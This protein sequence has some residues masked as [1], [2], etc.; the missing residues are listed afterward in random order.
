MRKF[1]YFILII[2]LSAC[3]E[4]QDHP[5]NAADSTLSI[6]NRCLT[7]L[8]LK[9]F[10]ASVLAQEIGWP[11]PVWDLDNLSLA[12][13]YFHPDMA[14]AQAIA[15]TADAANITAAQR[16]NPTLNAT[17][18][19]LTHLATAVAPWYAVSSLN[20][21]IET[22]G[23]RGF[24]MDKAQQLSAA[25]RLRIADAAWA[26][27]GRL[28]LAW[29]EAFAAQE[30]ERLA[31]QQLGL[32]Q[33]MATRLEQQLAAGEIS[34]Q[35]LLRLQLLLSQAQLNEN[36]AQKR[37]AESRVQLATALG[38]PVDALKEVALD[39]NRL[40]QAPALDSIPVSKLREIALRQ[41]PD[42]L[43][44]LADYAAAQ[45]ALQLE[46]AN[47]YPNIQANPG[48]AWEL[49]ENLWSLGAS[50]QLP[51]F[52]QNQG[53]IAEAEAKR[54]ELAVRFTALQSK[55]IGDIDRAHAGV[56]AVLAKQQHTEQQKSLQQ[57]N[58]WFAQAQFNAGEIDHL[59]LLTAEMEAVIAE[60]TRLDVS[61]ETQQTLNTLEDS[62]RTPINSAFNMSLIDNSA[63]RN[64]L[65]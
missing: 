57:Q 42:V 32:Q 39:F 33:A 47:Q 11:L 10:I 34:R 28:R 14:L 36:T 13:L 7:N 30:V 3:A 19:Y 43:A 56:A 35:D 24:R 17:P 9:Q 58:L 50:V 31:Q 49:G 1:L 65:Q 20:I 45:A 18:S 6:E 53:L 51:V 40:T 59:A 15:E 23:K 8:Q 63:A 2:S 54:R 38:L 26:V 16:P 29:L 48:Y 46:I 61:L 21:P 55:I 12:A 27:R 22:A 52:H 25:A 41:R 4:F 37:R 5:L 60:R 62:L 44:A 64:N